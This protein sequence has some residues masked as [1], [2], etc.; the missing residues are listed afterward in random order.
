MKND[1]FILI[2]N[3][4][5]ILEKRDISIRKL[6]IETNISRQT[7]KRIVENKYSRPGTY[8][9]MALANA[10]DINFNE[11]FKLELNPEFLFTEDNLKRIN[12]LNNNSKIEFNYDI[13]GYV[14]NLNSDNIR[15]AGEKLNI[16]SNYFNQRRISF[17]GN[18]AI[19]PEKNTLYI[20]DFDLFAKNQS[21]L[22]EEI[23]SSYIKILNTLYLTAEH[24]LKVKKIKLRLGIYDINL[25][26]MNVN[27][28]P[29]KFDSQIY[30]Y[31]K[32]NFEIQTLSTYYKAAYS[33]GFR[34]SKSTPK[35]RYNFDDVYLQKN[36]N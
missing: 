23:I 36:I 14:N 33:Y 6:S 24:I 26:S 21:V 7:I 5:N 34:L 11:I 3:L 25:N 1:K 2:N 18:L 13:Y 9:A 27:T 35:Y 12:V 17:C 19:V 20:R 29:E 15:Y 4:A 22:R 31:P 16:Y 30:S 10:L 28:S 8:V 32:N